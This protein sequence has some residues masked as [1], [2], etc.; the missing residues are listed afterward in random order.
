M[1]VCNSVVASILQGCPLL[2]ELTYVLLLLL[3]I[4]L[5]YYYDINTF[6]LSHRIYRLDRCHRV[7]DAA[8]DATESPFNP[9]VACL[10]L[11]EISMQACPQITGSVVNALNKTCVRLKVLNLSQV[12]LFCTCIDM[13]IFHFF[14]HVLILLLYY[15]LLLNSARKLHQWLF[16]RFLIIAK[17][18]H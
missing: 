3:F 2:S 14:L 8:F 11:E 16:R 17:S 12:C 1:Q 10:S 13:Y 7:T 18:C 4:L 6:I 9:L 15:T 5:Y